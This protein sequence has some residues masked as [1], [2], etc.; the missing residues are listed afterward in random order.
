M[1]EFTADKVDPGLL[2]LLDFEKA[3]YSVSCEFLM[4]TCKTLF[5]VMD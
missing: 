5:F 3:F 2:A 1:L 4:A